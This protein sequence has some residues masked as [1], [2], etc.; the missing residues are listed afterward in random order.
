[1]PRDTFRDVHVD[2][3]LSNFSVAHFQNTADF[4]SQR[5]FPTISVNHV[6][7][8]FTFYPSGYFN[9]IA[10]D[11]KR[12]E[13]GVA[14]SISYSTTM[15]DYHCREEALRVFISDRKRSNV[16]S[17]FQLD[18]EASILLTMS[19]LLHREDWFVNEFMLPTSGWTTNVTGVA[20]GATGIQEGG[21]SI[22]K[23]SDTASDPVKDMLDLHREMLRVGKRKPNK[24]IM[25]LDVYNVIRNHPDVMDRIRFTGSS[26]APAIAGLNALAQ[27]FELQEIIIM[28]TVLNVAPQGIED[29]VTGLPPTKD[30]FLAENKML[31]AS[32]ESGLGLMVPTAGL[33]F[34]H[35]RYLAQSV[36][37]GPAVRRYR[38]HPGK[39]GEYIEAEYSMD[40]RI[41]APDLGCVITDII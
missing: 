23:W 18:R 10:S 41:V 5:F 31:L 15:R 4:V 7:D 28:Q 34:M 22:L 27:L 13:E 36:S 29:P 9:R 14:N 32:V 21:G 1:M 25:T 26:N 33:T 19:L 2:R 11:S 12:A 35:N 8:K 30:V 16:D 3:P 20:S 6:S 37:G 38:E 40:Q 24:C 39:K 17:Q